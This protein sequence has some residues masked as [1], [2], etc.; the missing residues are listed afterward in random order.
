MGYL[1]MRFSIGHTSIYEP[2][3]QPPVDMITNQNDPPW[4]K[5]GL[6]R[7]ISQFRTIS[8]KK[9]ASKP[10]FPPRQSYE[11]ANQL[12]VECPVHN[13]VRLKNEYG[14]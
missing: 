12:A 10:M 13:Y 2:D 7:R 3:P 1:H 4:P 5:N 6:E 9:S 14:Y 11:Y 8:A